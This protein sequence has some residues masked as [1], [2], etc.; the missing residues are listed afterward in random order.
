M[1]IGTKL[2]QEEF[3]EL[4]SIGKQCSGGYWYLQIRIENFKYQFERREIDNKVYWEIT[5]KDKY[6]E[7]GDIVED[8][9]IEVLKKRYNPRYENKIIA[10]EEFYYFDIDLTFKKL[11]TGQTF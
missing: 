6:Y 9:E 7:I 4:K 3:D 1:K 10:G 5:S 11:K 8:D 2:T